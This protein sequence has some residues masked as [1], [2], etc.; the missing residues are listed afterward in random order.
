MKA[1]RTTIRDTLQE[2]IDEEMM[3]QLQAGQDPSLLLESGAPSSSSSNNKSLGSNNIIL[4]VSVVIRSLGLSLVQN[5]QNQ[6]REL[7]YLSLHN[8]EL[9]LMQK[10]DRDIKQ[11]RVQYLNIDNNAKHV[12]TFPVIF[13][14]QQQGL[15]KAADSKHYT[16][17]LYLEQNTQAKN[18]VL[19]DN[20]ILELNPL[21]V[22]LEEAFIYD[23]RDFFA[24]LSQALAASSPSQ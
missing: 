1:S 23:L 19:F 5:L 20:I 4:Q 22:R 7:L 9:I 14:P 10:E 15:Y 2:E 17:N 8:A 21:T 12:T 16:L 24:E 13:T 11:L 6:P 3:L 18:I